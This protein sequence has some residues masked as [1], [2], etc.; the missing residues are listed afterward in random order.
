VTRV[1]AKLAAK[2]RAELK[3]LNLHPD[4]IAALFG[5]SAR[6]VLNWTSA[7]S[8]VP[9]WLLPSLKLYSLLPAD[10]RRSAFQQLAPD[11]KAPAESAAAAA[12]AQAAPEPKAVHPF[13]RIED[14]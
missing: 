13:A 12:S 14:L 6:T 7:S 4:D 9:S 8:R 5:V 10:A 2:L 3:N 11:R 1:E